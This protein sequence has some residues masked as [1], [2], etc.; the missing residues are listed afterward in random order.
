MFGSS[1]VWDPVCPDVGTAAHDGYVQV[2][3]AYFGSGWMYWQLSIFLF[4]VE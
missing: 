2:T 1:C 4:T 3:M